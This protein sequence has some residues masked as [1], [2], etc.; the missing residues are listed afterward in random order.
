MNDPMPRPR[1]LYLRRDVTR[2]GKVIWYVIKHRGAPKIRING[3]YGSAE[4][5]AAYTAAVQ[6]M[7]PPKD[8]KGGKGTLAWAVGLYRKSSAWAG[9]SPATRKQR[10]NIWIKILETGGTAALAHITRQTITKGRDRRMQTPAA[11]RHFIETMRHFFVWAV[12]SELVPADPT[13]GVKIPKKTGEGFAPWNETDCA[14]Y[15]ARWPLG[16]RERLAYA[17]LRYTG[18]RRGDAAAVGRQHVKDGVIRLATQKTGEKVSIVMAAEL[19]EAIAA[20]PCGDLSF[21]ATADKR[22]MTKESFG[23]FMRDAC[24]A[25]GV[26]K[27]S[28]GL[29][30]LAATHDAEA[31]WSEAELEAKY[32]WRGGRMASHYTKSM[33]RERLSINASRRT[34]NGTSRLQPKIQKL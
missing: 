6:G 19:I 25:A 18:L 2:H 29:R 5:W 3:E 33:D 21:I 16:T 22:P 30:K 15:E 34:E 11:A 31:G 17:V 26:S 13:Q 14:R 12:E 1:P 24:R 7:E 28:H 9:L 8:A 23:N 20:G 27:S 4:F 10:D 32:G